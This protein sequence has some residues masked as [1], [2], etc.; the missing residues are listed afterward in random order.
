[1]SE[2]ILLEQVLAENGDA[3]ELREQV[4]ALQTALVKLQEKR[5]YV[6]P[7]KTKDNTIRFGLIG[8]T[9]I[10][11]LF[12]RTDALHEFYKHL[13]AEG[14]TICLHAGDVLDGC[15]MYKGHEFELYAHGYDAQEAA[16][17]EKWPQTKVHTYF[18]TGNH[19]Y[20]FTKLVGM[21]IGEKL[22][23]VMHNSTFVGT[24][25][26]TVELAATG[27]KTLRVGLV[28]PDGGTAYAIS[29]KSQKVA[30]ALP[31][32]TKPDLLGIGH[33]HKM[34]YLPMFRNIHIFQ[35]GCLQSQTPFM[36]RKPTPAHVGGWI[37]EVVL[38]DRKHLVTQV[39]AEPIAF[40]EPEDR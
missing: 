39:K 18:I 3:K 38:G 30:E 36:A 5:H 12:E 4:A 28:H 40:Y 37:V 15:K 7:V 16:L 34:D 25:S 9:H 11:S 26:A 20:S 22:E 6:I 24:D 29:Y 19:D 27:G 33:Y 10:G 23:A 31:G 32:G 14:I 17:R 1:M 13:E 21:K 35:V 8:D 2:E